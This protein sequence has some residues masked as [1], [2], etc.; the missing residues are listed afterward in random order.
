MELFYYLSSKY[1]LMGF[2]SQEKYVLSSLGTEML[3]LSHTVS[4]YCFLRVLVIFI[5]IFVYCWFR[6]LLKKQV[7]EPLQN[8]HLVQRISRFKNSKWLFLRYKTNLYLSA[9]TQTNYCEHFIVFWAVVNFDLYCL[10]PKQGNKAMY[11]N[12]LLPSV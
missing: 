1:S 8:N 11:Y 2:K 12:V 3:L 4:W 7:L 9:V 5:K 10:S 6:K